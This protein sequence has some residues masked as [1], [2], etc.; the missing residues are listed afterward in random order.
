M[1]ICL[2]RVELFHAGGWT[3]GWAGG[4]TGRQARRQTDRHDEPNS[5]FLQFCECA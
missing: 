4:Q 5:Q 2:V 1:K 3:D